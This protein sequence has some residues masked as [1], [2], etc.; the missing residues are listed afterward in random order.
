[1]FII[2]SVDKTVSI[3][4]DKIKEIKI[5]RSV[6]TNDFY[7]ATHYIIKIN[8]TI[9]CDFDMN[10]GTPIITREEMYKLKDDIVNLLLI[11]KK[12]GEGIF[13][14]YHITTDAKLERIDIDNNKLN[15]VKKRLWDN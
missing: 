15:E 3:F 12:Y 7:F 11:D 8:N 4:S 6:D 9:I 5:E 10:K 13:K 2:H 14:E 1:M